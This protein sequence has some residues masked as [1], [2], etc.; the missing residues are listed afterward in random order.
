[1]MLYHYLFR[2]SQIFTFMI[3]SCWGTKCDASV[4]FGAGAATEAKKV[5]VQPCNKYKC[6]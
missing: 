2:S 3:K 5:P 1:M 4:Y 6:T